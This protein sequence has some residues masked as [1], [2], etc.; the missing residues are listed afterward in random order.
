MGEAIALPERTPALEER[1]TGVLA[2]AVRALENCEIDYVVFGGV[3]SAALGRPRWTHDID[4]LVAPVDAGRALTAL[5]R[6][7]F[8]TERTNEHWIYKAAKEEIV[9]D[10]IF[11]TVGDIYLDA[12]MLEHARRVGFLGVE[13]F[14]AAPED[15]IVIKAIAHDE[16]SARHW[17]D[18][19]S[20]IASCD[21][22]WAYLLERSVRGA[23]RVLSLLIY[24]QSNDLVLPSWPIARL[25]DEIYVEEG[26]G[27]G[28]L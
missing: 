10:L 17:N 5:E 13:L 15:Q 1:F 4:F 9:V 12:P 11:R 14:V 8:E 19:L 7:G 27:A 2:D 26:I 18:A 25:F 16:P 3:G 21:I 23:K 28:A 24:A 6:A 22:D 20:L